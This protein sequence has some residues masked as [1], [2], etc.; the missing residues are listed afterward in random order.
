M[1][2]AQTATTGTGQHQSF[3][4]LR[5]AQSELLSD[6]AAKRYPHDHTPIPANG[7]Q[8]AIGIG[9]VVSR[10]VGNVGLVALAKPTLIVGQH[11][12]VLGER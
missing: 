6:H 1:T 10:G 12:E 4:S 5:I 9:G 3:H 8:E 7:A 11:G 2:L